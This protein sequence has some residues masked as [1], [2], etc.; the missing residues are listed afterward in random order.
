VGASP[1]T[2]SRPEFGVSHGRVPTNSFK[3]SRDSLVL[4]VEGE[5]LKL[6]LR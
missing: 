1:N 6:V 3:F 5:P 2:A 4:N